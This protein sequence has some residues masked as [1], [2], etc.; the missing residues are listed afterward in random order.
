MRIIEQ[1]QDRP[2][3]KILAMASTE[4]EGIH[5]DIDV[6]TV[7]YRCVHQR[8]PRGYRL[9]YFAMPDGLTFSYIG[10]YAEAKRAATAQ[11]CSRYKYKDISIQLCA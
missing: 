1:R 3:R 11:A 6:S 2:G 9:W 7:R 4:P 8:K 10:P 5:K